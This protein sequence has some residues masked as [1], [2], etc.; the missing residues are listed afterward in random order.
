[1]ILPCVI[2]TGYQ[3]LP[4]KGFEILP[5]RA[6]KNF[7]F[8]QSLSFQNFEPCVT[9]SFDVIQIYQMECYIKCPP[10]KNV[11]LAEGAKSVSFK[12]EQPTTNYDWDRFWKK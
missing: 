2:K 4:L 10:D 7:E 1:M 12:V 11:S 9:N 3:V 5:K 6:M 8:T